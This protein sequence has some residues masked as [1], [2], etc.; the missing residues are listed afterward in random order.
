[1]RIPSFV[2]EG[3]QTQQGNHKRAKE[4]ILANLTYSLLR[5]RLSLPYPIPLFRAP[6]VAPQAR[7]DPMRARKDRSNVRN[8]WKTDVRA[9]KSA[10]A[11]TKRII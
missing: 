5:K 8:G 10:S 3:G 4:V 7:H 6:E 11:R 1:M 9:D 2:V